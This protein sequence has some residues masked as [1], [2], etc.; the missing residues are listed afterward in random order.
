MKKITFIFLGLLSFTAFADPAPRLTPI[1]RPIPPIVRPPVSPVRPPIAVPRVDIG[2]RR[3]LPPQIHLNPAPVDRPVVH[4]MINMYQEDQ[5]Y[6]DLFA[7]NG[8]SQICG[9]TAMANALIYL[10]FNHAPTFPLIL[11]HS[12]PAGSTNGSY[13]E[14][15]F[16]LCKTNNN[17]GTGVI[18]MRNCAVD[19]LTEGGYNTANTFIRGIHSDK[20]NQRFAPGPGDLRVM[21]QTSWKPGADVS[22]SDRAVVLLLGWYTV[23]WKAATR[24][25]VYTRNGGHYVTL[26]GYDAANPNIFYVSNPLVDY[27]APG[28]GSIRYSKMTLEAI[29][30]R[31]DLVTAGGFKNEWQTYDLVGGNLAVL[32]DMIIVLPWR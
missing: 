19:A 10:R 25:W 16:D 1:P 13:V 22:K 28:F 2:F 27:N 21:S 11:Q 6:A 23:D 9:P 20:E 5:R 26:A 12:R 7:E 15:L 31:A 30:D 17:N 29:P 24:Q 8:S 14:T 4:P 32:E 18:N 3:N